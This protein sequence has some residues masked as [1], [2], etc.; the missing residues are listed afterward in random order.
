MRKQSTRGMK[1][2]ANRMAE[3]RKA[4]GRGIDFGIVFHAFRPLMRTPFDHPL[5]VALFKEL[6]RYL[7]IDSVFLVMRDHEGLVL[8]ELN[9]RLAGRLSWQTAYT[10]D[11][12]AGMRLD[13]SGNLPN[14]G[15][16][17]MD[18]EDL[19]MQVAERSGHFH[20][21][22]N[23]FSKIFDRVYIVPYD[24]FLREP[25]ATMRAIGKKVGTTL[26]DQPL[27]SIKLNSLGNRLLIYNP[28]RLKMP[29]ES[30]AISH[31]EGWRRLLER[32]TAPKLTLRFELRDVIKHCIDWGTYIPTGIDCTQKVPDIANALGHPIS[33]GVKLDDLQAISP[34]FRAMFLQPAFL[35]RLVEAIGPVF[36]ANYVYY[37][38]RYKD[39]VYLR[40]LPDSAWQIY[41]D[42]NGDEI[43]GFAE[44]IAQN[45]APSVF[46]D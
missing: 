28:I 26:C 8:S 36:Q 17:N 16:V 23:L 33:L 22:W 12:M 43:R 29:E 14:R 41:E 37:L 35:E 7:E 19:A 40:E 6:R 27:S 30:R 38:K 32:S 45:R 2:L 34:D 46:D 15:R 3:L 42:A 11:E 25:D 9:R 20:S 5:N 31:K 1:A 18:L 10:L 44:L 4:V 13:G 21:I 24:R 39:E